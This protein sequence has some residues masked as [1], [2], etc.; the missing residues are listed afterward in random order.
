[1]RFL[2]FHKRDNIKYKGK[3]LI[4]QGNHATL[5]RKNES[6]GSLAHLAKKKAKKSLKKPFTKKKSYDIM[7]AD[8]TRDTEKAAFTAELHP[9]YA[10][11][12]LIYFF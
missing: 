9:P 6:V 5:S 12:P 2:A 10:E 3:R 4:C 1:L 11:F 7:Y 8:D